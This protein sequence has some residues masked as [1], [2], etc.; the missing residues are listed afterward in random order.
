[1]RYRFHLQNDAVLRTGLQAGG[2]M[3]GGQMGH[4]S[5]AGHASGPSLLKTLNDSRTPF[6]TDDLANQ[7][8]ASLQ[9]LIPEMSLLP[10]LGWACPG[11]N[12]FCQ[13]RKARIQ[14]SHSAKS[15]PEAHWE[16]RPRRTASATLWG[17]GRSPS[18]WRWSAA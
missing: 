8:F 18:T 12:Q 7:E 4:S 1:M 3:A 10:G 17:L 11:T 13:S 14:E 16:P 5:K 15:H 6:L 9:E 2:Q